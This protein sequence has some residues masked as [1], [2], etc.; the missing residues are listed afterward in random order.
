MQHGLGLADQFQA[1]IAAQL[2]K[3][4]VAVEDFTGRGIGQNDALGGFVEELAVASF[5]RRKPLRPACDR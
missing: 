3:G 5:T 2:R 4:L 1:V